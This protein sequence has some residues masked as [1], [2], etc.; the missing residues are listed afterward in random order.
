MQLWG[1]LGPGPLPSPARMTFAPGPPLKAP[2]VSANLISGRNTLA[3]GAEDR[4]LLLGVPASE[5][6]VKDS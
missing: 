5:E 6:G 2:D 4:H 3:V 1:E